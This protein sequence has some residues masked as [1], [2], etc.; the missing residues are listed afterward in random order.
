MQNQK[1]SSMISLGRK[2]LSV[3]VA[4][5][6]LVL[7]NAHATG[8]GRLTVLSALGQPLHAEIELTSPNKDEVDS[9][10]PKLASSEAFKRANIDFNSALLSL[11]FA[12]EQRGGR[13]VIRVSSTQAMN[14]PFVDMLLEM[15]SSNGKLLREYTFLLD[16]AE[17]K[18]SQSPQITMPVQTRSTLADTRSSNA[19][20]SEPQKDT[21]V[22]QVANSKANRNQS[23][24]AKSAGEYQ[25]HSGDTLSKIA[26]SYKAEGISL[27]QMLVGLYRANPTAFVGKNMNR[28]KAGQILTIPDTNTILEKSGSVGNAHSIV[29]A[30]AADF[31]AYRNRLAS[32]VERA[33]VEKSAEGK[34]SASGAITTKVNEAS[35]V[36]KNS[37]DKLEV[38]KATALTSAKN[39]N[40]KNVA[41]EDKI[42][43]DKA[44][45]DANAR[46]K[47]L[48]KNVGDLQKLLDVKNK[49]LALKQAELNAKD[50][51]AKLASK[52][53][54]SKT[55]GL[56]KAPD[57][58]LES[59]KVE[60]PSSAVASASTAVASAVA[61]KSA[62]VSSSEKV[63]PV[64]K[65]RVIAPPPPPPEVGFF[66]G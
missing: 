50:G 12:V 14:E 61:A 47:E 18:N 56:G 31:N 25:V 63:K 16:P 48:E 32:H 40:G 60:S 11:Q 33:E 27:D 55:E 42:A 39:A 8:L 58:S 10:A 35:K 26:G 2:V 57:A 51:A 20:A 66:E 13:Y 9:L 41:E 46:L 4:S 34:Q 7:S 52:N 64:V 38:S 28:L 5:S 3:A 62:S 15:N 29:V 24:D 1:R 36:A 22:S 65:R 54:D 6:L 49:D 45:A 23:K 43:K 37:P 17:L 59:K 44:I 53:S 30:H 19:G 21:S